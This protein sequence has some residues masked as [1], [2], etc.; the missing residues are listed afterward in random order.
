MARSQ[1]VIGRLPAALLLATSFAALSACGGGGGSSGGGIISTP[2][3]A[4]D[5]E[6]RTKAPQR[7][8]AIVTSRDAQQKLRKRV[9]TT[10]VMTRL[11]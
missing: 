9:G 8:T 5:P 10:V 4:P 3:P 11:P 6:A 1:G 7:M 2:Q